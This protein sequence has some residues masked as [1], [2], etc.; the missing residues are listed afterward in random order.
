M[1]LL[2][3]T[4]MQHQKPVFGIDVFGKKFNFDRQVFGEGMMDVP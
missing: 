3:L 4:L 1:G 2:Y